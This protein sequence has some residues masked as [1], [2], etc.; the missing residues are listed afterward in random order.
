MSNLEDMNAQLDVLQRLRYGGEQSVTY[1]A[2]G[3]TRRVEYRS[4]AD[5][6]RAIEGD[7]LGAKALIEL[8]EMEHLLHGAVIGILRNPLIETT[9]RRMHN[10]LRLLRL[11]RKLTAPVALRT[12]R[13]HLEIL[14]ACAAR[15]AG[16]AQTA[17][18]AH[19][20]AAVQRNL[21]LL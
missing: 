5:L 3:V 12:L 4:Y 7:G 6:V 8:D 13:E 16:R 1:Q 9:Y 15:D 14:A 19:F 18:D 11:D 2:N 20:Q 21:G 10:Y 17:L